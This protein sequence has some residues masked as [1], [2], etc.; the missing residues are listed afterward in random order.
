MVVNPVLSVS[1]I[2]L[3]PASLLQPVQSKLHFKTQSLPGHPIHRL[4]ERMWV[5]LREKKRG[6]VGHVPS[7][8]QT[9][10][11][12]SSQVLALFMW[13]GLLASF[14]PQATRRFWREG[15]SSLLPQASEKS[16]SGSTQKAQFNESAMACQN[17]KQM[18]VKQYCAI[19]LQLVLG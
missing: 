17:T 10:V 4:T 1:I 14:P 16:E 2:W 7:L 15:R 3:E 5:K 13:R 8:Q 6:E 12:P 9:A 11:Q 18:V 19:C